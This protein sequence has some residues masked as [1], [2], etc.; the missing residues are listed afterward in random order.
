MRDHVGEFTCEVRAANG[1]WHHSLPGAFFPTQTA[2]EEIASAAKAWRVTR[3]GRCTRGDTVVSYGPAVTLSTGAREERGLALIAALITPQP[4][5][6][7]L[8]PTSCCPLS[9][10]QRRERGLDLLG[11]IVRA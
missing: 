3:I 7:G 5:R 4:R 1:N 2:A 11:S 9:G 10:M 8:T 6:A